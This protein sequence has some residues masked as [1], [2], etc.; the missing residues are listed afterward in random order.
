MITTKKQIQVYQDKLYF[1]IMKPVVEYYNVI[2]DDEIMRSFCRSLSFYQYEIVQ[3]VR[4]E[5]LAKYKT[6]PRLPNWIFRCKEKQ[7]K[8]THS[9]NIPIRLKEDI[10][11]NEDN[12]NWQSVRRSLKKEFGD[13]IFNSWL[14]KVYL[15]YELDQEVLM[16]TETGFIAD[17]I[18]KNYMDGIE[19]RNKDKTTSNPWIKKGIKQ[20]WLEKNPDLKVLRIKSIGSISD[21]EIKDI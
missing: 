7:Q 2:L 6:F 15:I 4:D 16:A 17:W 1:E 3:E 10:R 5:L 18:N 9:P 14:S 8:I 13:D 19:A 11:R 20:L 21:S 12:M